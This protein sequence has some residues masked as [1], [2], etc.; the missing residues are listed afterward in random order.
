MSCCPNEIRIRYEI[1]NNIIEIFSREF[2][3]NNK[4][5]CRIIYNENE[6]ELKNK[7]N[8]E[9]DK[10]N[11]ILQITLKI[12]INITNMEKMFYSYYPHRIPLISVDFSNFD[13]SN[14]TN[15]N[16][17]FSGCSLLTSLHGISSFDNS[18]VTNINSMF[19]GCSSLVS[20][21]FPDIL[22]WDTSK[23]E[24]MNHLFFNCSLLK[25][26]PDISN[27][28]TSKVYSLESMFKGCKSLL[29]LPDISKWD[30]SN[31]RSLESMFKGCRSLSLLPDISKWKIHGCS[32]K[33][34]FMDCSSLAFLPDISDDDRYKSIDYL[35]TGCL[36]LVSLPYIPI[37]KAENDSD[38][39]EDCL[40]LISTL[41]KIIK[42]EEEEFY[43]TEGEAIFGGGSYITH[44]WY[45]IHFNKK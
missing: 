1:N 5:K 43:Q 10:K 16:S 3:E 42:H 12:I 36:S 41:P 19:Y 18:N 17:M 6:Y 32:K 40:S 21:S 38:L 30:T 37:S 24:Y 35:F 45:T 15:M 25:S 8:I 44:K 14:V 28:D 2:V 34:M 4:N 11:K 31:V 20:D 29:S 13:S 7:L 9:N 26:I 33:A 27:L 23:V 22:N 39:F